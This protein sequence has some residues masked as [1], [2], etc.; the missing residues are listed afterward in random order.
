MANRVET[1]QWVGVSE[2]QNAEPLTG[3]NSPDDMRFQ[4]LADRDAYLKGQVEAIVSREWIEAAR[5]DFFAMPI[6]PVGWLKANGA[7]VSRTAYA[8]LFTV[9]GT[10][11]GAGN[12]STTFNLPDLRGEFLRGWDD[13]RG[14]D[15]GRSIGTAQAATTIDNRMVNTNL[16]GN[17]GEISPLITNADAT[18]VTASLPYQTST[19][20]ST[21]QT[22]GRN[23]VRPR[24][25]ALLACIKY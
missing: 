25:I 21:S 16:S 23:S 11:F 9:I 7:A 17:Q 12:G 14:V 3:P 20:F 10:T 15:S 13:G 5:I 24:N 2:M 22:G 4:A 19:S 1:A 8:K 18:S 6:P